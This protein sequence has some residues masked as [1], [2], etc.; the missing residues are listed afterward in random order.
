MNQSQSSPINRKKAPRKQS[1]KRPQLSSLSSLSDEFKWR[2]SCVDGWMDG[3]A[4]VVYLPLMHGV[5]K[6]HARA[7]AQK[8]KAAIK[9]STNC[10]LLAS[11]QL[12]TIGPTFL[13]STAT[14]YL[15]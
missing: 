1:V 15:C 2:C 8:Q 12:F 7:R 14:Y 11:P 3:G 6:D 13:R 9:H 4:R 5:R 10:S